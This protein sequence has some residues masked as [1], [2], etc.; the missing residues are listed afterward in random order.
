M[1]PHVDVVHG[2]PSVRVAGPQVEGWV[3]LRGGHLAPVTFRSGG[4]TFQPYSLAPWLPG[5]NP[6]LDPVL[7]VLRGDFWCLPFGPQ[8]DGVA[9]G[10]AASGPWEVVSASE[11][12]VT[13]AQAAADVG[14]RLE[15][16]VWV[17][18]AASGQA[19][20]YQEFRVDGVVGRFPVGSHPVLDMSRGGISRVSTSPMR[21]CSVAPG[22][23]SDPARGERQVLAPG[24]TFGDLSAVPQS[25]GSTLD[26]STYP[27]APGHEDLVMLVNDPDAGPIGWSAVA[28]P[29]AV[30]FQLKDIRRLPATLLWV[31]NGGRSQAPWSGRH[32]GR[33]G[34][35]DVCSYFAAGLEESRQDL[36]ADLGIPTTVD[37][38][39]SDPWV[40]RTVHAVAF[41]DRPFGRV[42]DVQLTEPGQVTLISDEGA[43]CPVAVDWEVVLSSD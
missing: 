27:T 15:R 31:T 7:D 8:S 29:E 22:L 18:D 28:F 23:F 14:G 40:V 25:D 35:E 42:A 33:M 36:L 10:L 21:W 30:W 13:M 19:A 5:E 37:F 41:P 34:I 1:D 38:S 4:R 17:D 39:G 11:S 6:G 16:S 2:E 3:T 26:L 20:I 12:R 32:V 9:H 43:T 24:A